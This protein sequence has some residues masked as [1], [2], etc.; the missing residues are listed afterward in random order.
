MILFLLAWILLGLFLLAAVLLLG[1][2]LAHQE[3]SSE[4]FQAPQAEIP[5]HSQEQ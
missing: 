5:L 3:E 2:V 1:I 4:L